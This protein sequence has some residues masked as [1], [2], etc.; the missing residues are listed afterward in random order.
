MQTKL[1]LRIDDRLIERA[2][3]HARAKGR[4]V[5][6]MVSDYFSLL[7]A[8]PASLDESLPPVVR[9]LRG[10]LAGRRIDESDYTRH[11]EKKHA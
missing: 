11:L 5:S 9:S 3:R 1:T 6:Q 10:S 8:D 4:S 7:G 2:K